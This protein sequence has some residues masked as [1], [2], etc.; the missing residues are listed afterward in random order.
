MVT[1][2]RRQFWDVVVVV[3]VQKAN[4]VLTAPHSW[5]CVQ[6]WTPS[7]GQPPEKPLSEEE[8]WRNVRT[9]SYRRNLVNASLT[10]VRRKNDLIF[11]PRDKTDAPPI[12]ESQARYGSCCELMISPIPWG[13]LAARRLPSYQEWE[14]EEREAASPPVVY[15]KLARSDELGLVERK[16]TRRRQFLKPS[17]KYRSKSSLITLFLSGDNLEGTFETVRSGTRNYV[18][19]FWSSLL[20]TSFC[21]MDHLRG[22]HHYQCICSLRTYITYQTRWGYQIPWILTNSFPH[23]K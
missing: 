11:T 1:S 16:G 6:L 23:R 15:A 5:H 19:G 2:E 4:I 13:Q 14:C 3:C 9:L 8:R 20:S 22:I 7:L 10:V 12:V 21:G 18:A 17:S